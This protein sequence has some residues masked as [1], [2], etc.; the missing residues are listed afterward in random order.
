MS[1]RKTERANALADALAQ[2]GVLHIRDAAALLG[3]S[4]MTVRRDVSSTPDRF[5]YLGGH[6]VSADDI[7]GGYELGREADSHAGAKS[8]ACA[9]A[10]KLIAPDDT[11][12][13]DCGS[14]L[15]HLA[16]QIPAELTLTVIC[17]SLNVA[18]RLAQKPNL[19]MIMLGGLYH[20]SSATF[21]SGEWLEPLGRFGINKAFISAGGIDVA[22][23]ASCSHFHE[24]PIK[25]K[26]IASALESHLVIDSSKFGTVK[27]AYFARLTDFRSVITE[28]GMDTQD[29]GRGDRGNIARA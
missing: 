18:E 29:A 10:L 13:I 15:D 19:R 11:V 4:E 14:T 1:I 25:Q 6:I 20:P 27:P 21:S 24:V 3:V 26:A 5:A 12:F 22:R 9:H 8:R 28:A 17:Y 2:R 16:Q 23:G 7:A